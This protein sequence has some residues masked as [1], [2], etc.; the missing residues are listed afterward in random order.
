VPDRGVNASY[1]L[2]TDILMVLLQPLLLLQVD[3]LPVQQL[4]DMLT[5]CN[6]SS[7]GMASCQQRHDASSSS[8]SSSSSRRD[9]NRIISAGMRSH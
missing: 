7:G 9:L 5:A 6:S 8:S 1:M 4:T 2:R 3:L